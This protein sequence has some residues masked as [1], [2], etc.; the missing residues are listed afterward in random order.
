FGYLVKGHI[1]LSADYSQIELVILAHLSGDEK[2]IRAFIQ[3]KDIHTHTASLI[4]SKKESEVTP[5]ERR[6]GKTIN[7][8][9][10]YGMS[11]FRLSRDLKISRKDADTFIDAYFNEY[12]QVNLLKKEIIKNAEKNGYVETIMGRQRAVPNIKNPN[13]TVKMADER[14]AVNTPI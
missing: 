9:V 2:L 6:I 3:G 4:F 8:G 13:K 14:I 7:F 12:S 5:S 10:M 11:A 1:L